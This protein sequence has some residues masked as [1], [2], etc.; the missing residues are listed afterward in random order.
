MELAG[1][2]PKMEWDSGDLP[3]AWKNFKEHCQFLF[4]GPLQE[5]SE[6]VKCNY[7]MI[8]V[9]EKG[10]KVYSTWTLTED[11]QKLIQTYY[12]K[13][14]AYVEPKSNK[15]FARYKFQCKVQ[16]ESESCEQFVTSLKVLVKDCG[17]ADPDQMV[18]D[19]IVFGTKSSKV[20]EKLINQGSDLTLEKAIEIAQVQEM[21]QA[22]LKTMADEDKSVTNSVNF[23]KKKESGSAHGNKSYPPRGRGNQVHSSQRSAHAYTSNRP[24]SAHSQYE[25]NKQCNRCGYAEHQNPEHC[26][27]QG[28]TCRKCNGKDHFEKKCRSGRPKYRNRKV[29]AL[30]GFESDN[31]DSDNAFYIGMLTLDINTINTDWLVTVNVNNVPTK[32]QLDTG[33]K[34][35]VMSYKTFKSLNYK[36]ALKQPDMPLKS[37]SGHFIKAIGM[38]RLPCE[39]KGQGYDLHFYVID[40]DA[41]ALLGA[42]TCKRMNLLTRVDA[43]TNEPSIAD[44]QQETDITSGKF[45]D[46]FDGLGCLPGIHT[47]KLDP[48]IKPIIHPPRKLPVSLRDKVRDELSR[49]EEAGVI[50]KEPEPTEWVNSMVVVTKPNKVRIC[51]DPK[52]LNRAIQREH[53]PM[54]TV[55]EVVANMPNAKV[56]S[57]LD[58]TSGFWQMRL[59]DASSK[60]C[61]YNTP[62]GRYR[63][64]RMP[65]GIKSAPE[66]FQKIMSQMV[67]DI[68]GADS[69]IDDILVWGVD[70]AQHDERL[71]R[72]LEKARSYNLKLSPGKCQFRKD[73]VSYVGHV[74]GKD[75]LKP[76]PEKIRAVESMVPPQNKSELLTFL[77][78]MQYL[79][80]FM[81][82]M[83]EIS[84]PLR[85]LTEKNVAWYWTNVEEQSF[86]TLKTL[87]INAPVLRFYDPALPLTLSVDASSKGL[88]AVLLQEG[89][90]I[91]Y[92]SR[93]L[94]PAQQNYAQIEKETLAVVYGCIKFHQY[95]YG[96]NVHVETDH[97]PLQ[98]IFNKPLYQAPLRLQRLLLAI[99]RYDLTVTYK[100]GKLMWLADTLSRAY[101]HET[102]E[103][104][105]PEAEVNMLNPKMYLPITPEKYAK[106]QE[107]T[108]KD[109]ALQQLQEVVLNGWP[110]NRSDLLLDLIPYW[111]YKDEIACID[112]LLYKGQ[113]LIVPKSMRPEMLDLIHSSHMG[114]VKCKSRARDVIFWPGMSSQ[115]EDKVLSCSQCAET[116]NKNPKEPMVPVDLPERPWAKIA[117]DIFELN[118]QN[119]LLTVDYYSKFPEINKLDNLTTNNV[120]GYL[121]S[122]IARYGIPDEIVTDNGPQFASSEFRAF[123]KELG[124]IHTTSSPYFAQSNGQAERA[125]QTVKHLMK[126]SKDPYMALLDYRNT[127]LDIGL[128]PAQLLF[129][130]RL[131][132][133]LPTTSEL[134]KTRT[135]DD[136]I[137]TELQNRQNKYG[138]Y[139]NQKASKELPPLKVNDSVIMQT[140]DKWTSATVQS[141][142]PTPRS[143]VVRA[144]NG[145]LYRRNRKML[146]PSRASIVPQPT[147]PDV[148]PNE[149]TA[150]DS[151]TTN[152]PV[153]K[154]SQAPSQP[155]SETM[156]EPV[157]TRSGR[158]VKT[159]SHLKDYEL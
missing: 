51:L 115:I 4:N 128:S 126:K 118:S 140:G 10:R 15:V 74:I 66:V 25:Q 105:L 11:E 29:H 69:I 81:P 42:D 79:S 64:T 106:F 5:K 55:E 113:K 14:Q 30:E 36:T 7:L 37:Y 123:I 114:V 12:D 48:T 95:V 76:D 154:D 119:Y 103:E 22:Q 53:F 116:Q 153:N 151:T 99:Q 1:A 61:T 3:T 28:K 145:K 65:F 49:M 68:D 93:A 122:Q 90:P 9:G 75:G 47:I 112:G 83:S 97:K 17:Y 45:A 129:G 132:T 67:E 158:L 139:Y 130:R 18:R 89:Q 109:A 19:R 88:G 155:D 57:K 87:A 20:R 26:P 34:C 70:Q 156:H 149:T 133:K 39:F 98:A 40:M 16:G 84:A 59:D 148:Y 58:A 138:Y 96:R 85:K 107:E 136:Q 31:D 41:P 125:I 54:K 62:F 38:T 86:Q 137:A 143:Y 150:S 146:R 100:P 142:H 134:L 157:T 108:A 50:V 60:L 94:T 43:I 24:K 92:G 27:A 72:V 120:V 44:L 127:P 63:F 78:F 147:E 104:L 77:G 8:W 73:E 23:V 13:F 135:N 33:A 141:K 21:S 80:K 159:P 32:F 117:S 6:E 110:E 71:N 152:V 111:S 52:D 124:I 2:T 35:N 101:L 82:N 144:P 46:L 131:K 102:K 56:F 121:K 91:T